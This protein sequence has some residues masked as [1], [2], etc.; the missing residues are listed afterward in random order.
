MLDALKLKEKNSKYIIFLN[1]KIFLK[2][3]VPWR[4]RR[5]VLSN[6]DVN[7]SCLKDMYVFLL[8]TAHN[9]VEENIF[10]LMCRCVQSCSSVQRQCPVQ[11]SLPS[12]KGPP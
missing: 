10:P 8:E 7:A 11:D 12:S 2:G 1:C 6:G 3:Y 5:N 4:Q 9:L